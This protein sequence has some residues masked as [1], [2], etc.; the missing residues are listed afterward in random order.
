MAEW[1]INKT[2]GKCWGTD[3]EFAVGENY[4]AALMETEEGFERRDYSVEY[5]QE[6][7]VEAYCFWKTKMADP[8][9]K[10]QLFIDDEMLM[11]FFERL[12]EETEE[13]KLNF[14][15]VLTLVLM[16]KRK[17]KYMDHVME[18]GKEVWQMRVAGEGRM[19]TVVNP[20]LTEDKIEDL[21]SQIG[22]IMQV[23]L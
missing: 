22:Q 15:F 11:A 16:R 23:D 6:H 18:E 13:E 19:V 21:S 5:W 20:E 17:L 9:E 7:K 12:A 4:Y 8:E 14:R 3:E 1:E 2:L 10:K